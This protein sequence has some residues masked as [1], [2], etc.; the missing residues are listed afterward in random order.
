MSHNLHWRQ[1]IDGLRAFAVIAV[2]FYHA[3][4]SLAPGGF[5]G[6]DV[7]FVISGYLITNLIAKQQ[8]T[9]QFTLREFYLRRA[10]RI[11]PVLFVVLAA[12][13]VV[14]T[15]LFLPADFDF[16]SIVLTYASIGLSNFKFSHKFGYFDHQ[17]V[18][19]PLLHTWSLGVEE[20]FYMA[21]PALMIA[22]ARMTGRNRIAVYSL[23]AAVSFA[24]CIWGTQ[25]EPLKAFY[26]PH[27]RA[28]EFLIGSIVALAPFSVTDRLARE[29]LAWFGAGLLLFA[30]GTFH[31][32]I[33]FPGAAAAIPCLGAAAILAAGQ[34]G[35]TSVF[36]FL[37][38]APMRFLGR[39]SYS[40]YLWH[41]PILVFWR[42]SKGE[43]LS[44]TQTLLALA[45]ALLLSI[46]TWAV[47][48]EPVRSRQ[49]LR[50]NRSLVLGMLAS[51]LVLA[52][53]GLFGSQT[54]G[55]PDRFSNY[56][57]TSDAPPA[58]WRYGVC[59]LDEAKDYTSWQADRCVLN[60]KGRN[61]VLLWGDSYAGHYAFG[62]EQEAAHLDARVILYSASGCP[63]VV[64]I[65]VAARPNCA[66]FVRNVAALIKR[67]HVKT[68]IMS[69]RWER[70]LG[71][72]VSIR[73][74]E[75]TIKMMASMGVKVLL[76]S[77][78][79]SFEFASPY[80]YHWVTG[81]KFARV[82]F[83]PEIT[84]QILSVRGA[85]A[86]FDPMVAMCSGQVCP[87]SA[88]GGWLYLDD[89]HLTD[90]G[91]SLQVKQMARPLGDLLVKNSGSQ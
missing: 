80:D 90:L 46:L 14:A 23:V 16:L 86:V 34:T 18:T 31:D 4:L 73:K 44:T 43:P 53:Y 19:S 88:P 64:N 2:L 87:T 35:S 25:T 68:V 91:S 66:A 41:W 45:A 42:Y 37:S 69:A 55:W 61:V 71:K 30:L 10:R 56:K 15:F 8:A 78:G 81:R 89:G 20:Q 26:L 83:A 21:F 76:V 32:G 63:P 7:F 38:T 84:K 3:N 47:V 22:T 72:E 59:F 79:P 74:I 75:D 54:K 52:S 82:K 58:S 51:V 60:E 29:C 24:L 57:S 77:Q 33:D 11:L 39:I 6:V 65:E 70:Y 40:L 50:E 62:L 48:E 5:I 85:N 28:W 67:H 12:V 36:T 1:D 49:I 17:A 13:A 9:N 27:F